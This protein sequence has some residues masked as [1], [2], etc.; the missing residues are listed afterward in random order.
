MTDEEK[1][2]I[3]LYSLWARQNEMARKVDRIYDSLVS[4]ELHTGWIER[5]EVCQANCKN[6]REAT[7]GKILWL[8]LKV[9]SL[10][11]FLAGLGIYTWKSS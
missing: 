10:T 3:T 6:H 9:Y 7:G 4:D 8:E 2:A 5:M 1:D 11:A